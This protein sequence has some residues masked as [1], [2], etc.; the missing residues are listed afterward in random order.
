MIAG[1]EVFLDT[2]ILIY[3][4]QGRRVAPE[5]REI[6]RNIILQGR[7]GTSGQVLAEFFSLAT[8]KG[9]RPLSMETAARWVRTLA[10]KPCQSIDPPLVLAAVALSER[11]RISYRDAAIIAAAE[12]LGAKVVYSENLNHGQTYGSVRV[13]NPFLPA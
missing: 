2:H 9:V 13:E 3:A 10:K 6:A 5:K 4:A 12:R 7:Y 11:Y 1:A 8:Q